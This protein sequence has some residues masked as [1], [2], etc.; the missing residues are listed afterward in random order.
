MPDRLGA[1][2]PG[3]RER[4]SA[5]ATYYQQ[6]SNRNRYERSDPR[7]PA[8]QPEHDSE[9]SKPPQGSRPSWDSVQKL[10][11][12]SQL[13]SSHYFKQLVAASPTTHDS[14]AGFGNPKAVRH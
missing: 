10:S 11:P 3:P 1:A 8:Q 12:P 9:L 4:R 5:Q 13:S 2:R 14:Y 6:T 7:D